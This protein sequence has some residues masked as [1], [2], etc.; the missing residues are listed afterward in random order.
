MGDQKTEVKLTGRPVPMAGAPAR[1]M[2]RRQVL[3]TLLAGAGAG[4]AL[5][6]V[7]E[8]HPMQH[9]LASGSAVAEA[10]AKA[11]AADWTRAFLSEHDFATLQLLAERILPGSRE[12]KVAE[13]IDQLL[14]VDS[15]AN[16]RSF[17][18]ALG[19]MEAEARAHTGKPWAALGD[20]EQTD[21]LTAISTT[22]SGRPAE[23]F[24]TRGAD[25]TVPVVPKQPVRLTVRD[26]FDS[27]KG[28]IS[29]AYY[30]TEVGLKELGWT[31]NLFF[32][33]FPGCDHPQGHP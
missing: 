30:S 18:N 1:G 14:A 6:M 4:V 7:A 16:Q 15:Q 19:A 11:N 8:G 20:A 12:V 23:V 22:E 13:F 2:G 10:D 32:E 29:G 25:M 28:W 17:L 5:P 9:H 27:L 33:S 24:W 26:H 21:L 3:Q 31:G